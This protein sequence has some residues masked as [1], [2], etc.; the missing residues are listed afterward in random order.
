MK[1]T[2]TM[3]T[4]AALAAALTGCKSPQSMTQGSRTDTIWV[5]RTDTVREIERHTE[6]RERVVHDSTVVER[7]TTG[8][9]VYVERWH[10]REVKVESH[11]S[12]DKYRAMADSLRN[13]VKEEKKETVVVEKKRRLPR[14]AVWAI[15]AAAVVLSLKTAW[16][17]VRKLCRKNGSG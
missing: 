4:A 13:I 17:A 1:K 16:W 3:M 8:K 7:D 6:V 11:D 10:S 2:I 12:V 5:H 9:V 15:S 14:I